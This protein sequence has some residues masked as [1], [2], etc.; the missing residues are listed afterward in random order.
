M[1]PCLGR[2]LA[3]GQSNPAKNNLGLNQ[4][5]R[6][7][8]VIACL[9]YQKNTQSTGPSFVGFKTSFSDGNEPGR[10]VLL[11]RVYKKGG[12]NVTK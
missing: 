4:K 2:L 10:P 12:F 8:W 9:V 1:R 6:A 3:A 7:E 11:T 5:K